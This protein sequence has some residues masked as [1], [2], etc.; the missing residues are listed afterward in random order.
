VL[1]LLR[2]METAGRVRRTGQRRGTRWHAVASEEEW[3]SERA[4]EL[5]ARTR[6]C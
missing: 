2:E 4:A 3:I 5:E 1:P 6:A